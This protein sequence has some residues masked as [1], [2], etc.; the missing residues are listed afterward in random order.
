[1]ILFQL[2]TRR[3]SKSRVRKRLIIGHFVTLIYRYICGMCVSSDNREQQ[4]DSKT[5]ACPGSCAGGWT[6]ADCQTPT[7]DG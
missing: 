3:D 4:C 1:M 6:G 5:G 2:E 7:C